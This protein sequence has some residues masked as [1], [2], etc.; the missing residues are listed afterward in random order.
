ML[1]KK[2]IPI[3]VQ[4]ERDRPHTFR[5]KHYLVARLEPIDEL[6]FRHIGRGNP[7]IVHD[8]SA[9][10][11]EIAPKIMACM[12]AQAFLLDLMIALVPVETTLGDRV[13]APQIILPEIVERNQ[14]KLPETGPRSIPRSRGFRGVKDAMNYTPKISGRK[15]VVARYC[16]DVGFGYLPPP[17]T[18]CQQ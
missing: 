9:K 4:R 11:V 17:N 12:I 1:P 16:L 8:G 7:K 5:G 14:T 3:L 15:I 6:A 18:R 13:F 10:I 2:L